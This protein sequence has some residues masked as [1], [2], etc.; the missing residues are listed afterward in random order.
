[1]RRLALTL[2]LILTGSCASNP[3]AKEREPDEPEH[4]MIPIRARNGDY[5]CAETLPQFPN[6]CMPIGRFREIVTRAHAEP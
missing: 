2:I 1:M 3:P 5:V 6:Y 4:F